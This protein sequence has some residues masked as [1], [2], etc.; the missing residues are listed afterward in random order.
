VSIDPAL[1]WLLRAGLALLFASAA[2][3]KLRAPKAFATTLER[4][5]L[6]PVAGVAPAAAVLGALEAAV[7]VWLVLPL[8]APAGA[9]FAAA[10]L[11]ALYSAAIAINLAR[12]RREID[13]GCSGPA[14]R[15]P[16]RPWLLARNG[17]VAVAALALA[18]P[19]LSR[20]LHW[21]DATTLGGG[22]VALALLW[23]A[24]HALLADAPHLAVPTTAGVPDGG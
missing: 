4:Y 23:Q 11:L 21:V 20:D 5:R 17:V 1:Q 12:G 22:L 8:A 2:W 18:L 6:L 14:R 10:A 7:A 9:G 13:C 19:T 16:I 3:H 15:Q 24:V